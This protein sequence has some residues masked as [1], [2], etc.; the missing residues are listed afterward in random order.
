MHL[1]NFVLEA[2]R[3]ALLIGLEQSIERCAHVLALGPAAH[4]FSQTVDAVLNVV[5]DASALLGRLHD[6]EGAS[7]L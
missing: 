7:D 1:A 2:L 3:A 5:E 6:V 4:G